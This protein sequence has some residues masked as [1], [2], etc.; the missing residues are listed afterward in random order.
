[1]ISGFWQTDP[2]LL[3]K[4]QTFGCAFLDGLYLLPDDFTPQAVNE[5]YSGFVHGKLIDIDCTILSWAKFLGALISNQTILRYPLQFSRIAG[6]D[7]VCEGDE[8]EII[9]WHLSNIDEDH[10]TVGDGKSKVLWDSMNRPDIMKKYASFVQ[11][12]VVKVG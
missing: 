8:R 5:M 6:E 7:Y 9:K 1:M 10:F 4:V 11:K 12:V 2:R 3:Q